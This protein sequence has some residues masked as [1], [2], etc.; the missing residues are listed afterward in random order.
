VIKASV[1]LLQ[2]GG[3]TSDMETNVGGAVKVI[4]FSDEQLFSSVTVN[5]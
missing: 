3:V 2:D 4:A 5:V 1:E